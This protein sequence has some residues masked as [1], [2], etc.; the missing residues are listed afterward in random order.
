MR[1][2]VLDSTLFKEEDDLLTEILSRS[3]EGAIDALV[4]IGINSNR[5]SIN[6]KLKELD[7]ATQCVFGNRMDIFLDRP[8]V[9]DFTLGLRGIPQYEI[10][11]HDSE[12]REMTVDLELFDLLKHLKESV[13][14]YRTDT[15]KYNLSKLSQYFRH[16]KT[17]MN[18]S[19][20]F[21]E[22]QY[23]IF[24]RLLEAIFCNGGIGSSQELFRSLSNDVGITRLDEFKSI[25]DFCSRELPVLKIR[26]P[27]IAE[28]LCKIL[29]VYSLAHAARNDGFELPDQRQ[30]ASTFLW[31]AAFLTIYAKGRL[32]EHQSFPAFLATFRVFELISYAL[33][34]QFSLLEFRRSRN[35]VILALNDNKVSGF[36]PAWGEL[37][38]KVLKPRNICTEGKLKELDLFIKLRNNL[39]L[40]HG[41][42]YV[43]EKM[44]A[45]FLAEILKYASDI[46]S[47]LGHDVLPFKEKLER[48]QTAHCYDVATIAIETISDSLSIEGSLFAN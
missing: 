2:H 19:I 25:V 27:A 28:Q 30:A 32:A 45:K 17:T 42:R 36:G 11:T 39:V 9:I 40:V 20:E 29:N 16:S 18:T 13:E 46:E 24:N 43:N 3:D 6:S 38:S 41:L 7:I 10:W 23:G 21:F 15:Q 44:S 1:V 34:L 37:K 48:F 4:L 5:R 12:P 22:Q 8:S 35:E 26:S 47:K 14:N 31:L 33:L